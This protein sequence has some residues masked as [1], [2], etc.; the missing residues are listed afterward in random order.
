[1]TTIGFS[2]KKSLGAHTLVYPTLWKAMNRE[3]KRAFGML[4]SWLSLIG[5]AQ[6]AKSNSLIVSQLFKKDGFLLSQFKD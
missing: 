3:L 6:M 4:G 5:L 1:M 2:L